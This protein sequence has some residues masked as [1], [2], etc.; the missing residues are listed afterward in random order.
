MELVLNR[1]QTRGDATPGDLFADGA[2]QCYTLEDVVRPDGEKVYGKTAI[3]GGGRRYRLTLVDS[4]HFGPDTIHVN[5]VPNFEN[6]HMHG[7]NRPE[8]TL[9]CILVGDCLITTAQGARIAGGTSQPALKVL[10]AKVK[11]AIERGEEVWLTI[12]NDISH[13]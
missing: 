3:P 12:N 2:Q 4:P 9:G 6:V 11:A 1:R 10:K 8:D 5:D 7:G 13:A